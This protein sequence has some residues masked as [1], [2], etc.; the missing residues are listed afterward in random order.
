MKT[1][2]PTTRIRTNVRAGGITLNHGLRVRTSVRAGGSKVNH[3]LRV[4][5]K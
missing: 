5:T 4:R 2:T 3:G 1:T